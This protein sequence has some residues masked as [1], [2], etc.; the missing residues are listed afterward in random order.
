MNIQLDVLQQGEG[1]RSGIYGSTST[2]NQDSGIPYQ[3]HPVELVE[4]QKNAERAETVQIAKQFGIGTAMRMDAD[5]QNVKG[6]HRLPGLESNFVGHSVL[7]RTQ[8]SVGVSD[9]VASNAAVENR[10]QANLHITM[11]HALGM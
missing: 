6:F 2:G 7:S 3:L 10:V 4:K 5:R 8:A 11:E 1:L 9:M